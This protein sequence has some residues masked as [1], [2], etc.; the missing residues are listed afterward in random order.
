MLKKAMSLALAT[1][2]LQGAAS[3]GLFCG[4]VWVAGEALLLRPSGFYPYTV[5]L[6]PAVD[7]EETT[8]TV[9]VGDQLAACPSYEWGYKVEVGYRN[10][11]KE[12][13]I[14]WLSFNNSYKSRFSFSDQEQIWPSI[15]STGARLV[16]PGRF[17]SMDTVRYDALDAEAAKWMCKECSRFSGRAFLGLRY[18]RLRHN[19]GSIT[20][21]QPSE[22][23]EVE[24]T[25]SQRS[26]FQGIGPRAGLGGRWD[27]WCNFGL[28]GSV[29]GHLLIGSAKSQF[30][31]TVGFSGGA[32]EE[33][34]DEVF[35]TPA[36]AKNRKYCRIIPASEIKFGI[37][38]RGCLFC[39]LSGELG[40]G[41]QITHYFY[42]DHSTLFTQNG[43]TAA[44]TNHVHTDPM[45][46]DGW[47]FRL[48]LMY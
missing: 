35:L 37:D 14:N 13:L 44:G 19:S 3:A 32:A 21:A 22:G 17:E 42:G 16:G 11:D 47:Y 9:P 20:F 8:V 33:L 34:Q 23:V 12:I 26:D 45:S 31:N 15:S 48:G 10:C 24:Q 7:S 27:V 25:L 28:T 41:Y 6:G 5:I 18:A 29:A 38:W 39:G 4:N 43:T 40:V 1:L 46:F 30:I 2:M 36:N